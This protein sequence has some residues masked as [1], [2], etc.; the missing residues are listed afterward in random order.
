MRRLAE[1]RCAEKAPIPGGP[2]S[3]LLPAAE[4]GLVEAACAG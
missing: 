4:T 3:E 1:D 2:L